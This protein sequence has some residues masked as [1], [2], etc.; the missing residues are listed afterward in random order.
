MLSMGTQGNNNIIITKNRVCSD[1]P[2]KAGNFLLYFI[3][4]N[5][6]DEHIFKTSTHNRDVR[7]KG[8]SC[9]VRILKT[10]E[11]NCNILQQ[12]SF[13]LQVDR[14]GY[15]GCRKFGAGWIFYRHISNY[16]KGGVLYLVFC[17]RTMFCFTTT[18]I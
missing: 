2:R 15:L 1:V 14:Q 8:S 10:K 7:M 18:R 16:S 17:P 11:S 3:W 5:W 9:T 13:I 12:L 6:I 4:Q